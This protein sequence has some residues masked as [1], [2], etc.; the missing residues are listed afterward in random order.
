MKK[1]DDPQTLEDYKYIHDNFP[2][3]WHD[4]VW[5]KC[6]AELRIEGMLPSIRCV[7]WGGPIVPCKVCW[8]GA[9]KG[10][11]GGVTK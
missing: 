11:N 6:V 7:K 1:I 3:Q 9:I 4:I 5:G 10:W 2:E 8:E